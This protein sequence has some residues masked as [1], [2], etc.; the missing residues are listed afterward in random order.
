MKDML[1]SYSRKAQKIIR[2]EGITSFLLVASL[3]AVQ[4][5]SSPLISR[6]MGS[7]TRERGLEEVV[8]YAFKGGFSII[9][10][11]Q[12]RSEIIGLLKELDQRR[13]RCIIEIGTARGGT[14]FLLTRV[15]ADDCLMISIDLLSS[16]FRGGYP[17][18]KSPF[19]K[20]FAQEEQDLHL[21]RADSH[22][23][24][25]RKKVEDILE[26]RKAD[27]L[28]I[29]GDHSYSGVKRDFEVYCPLVARGGMVAFHDIADPKEGKYG[30]N[31]FWKEIKDSY[32]HKELI[33][34]RK[35]GWAGIGILYM[36]WGSGP[37]QL[38]Q[39]LLRCSPPP[40]CSPPGAG[41][42]GWH[43][44]HDSGASLID[45]LQIKVSAK[46]HDLLRKIAITAMTGKGSGSEDVSSSQ[47]NLLPMPWRSSPRPWQRMRV[48]TGSMAWRPRSP[49]LMQ[50]SSWSW[51]CT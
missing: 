3:N 40:A 35:Q 27:L 7:Y 47:L 9:R 51:L 22:D 17:E 21:L 41:L 31:E 42:A 25:T 38:W 45:I 28:F 20:S 24:A 44:S 6:R 43:L 29:D 37:R 8:D 33:E 23:S 19:Y 36:K 4:L 34:D 50:L 26:G 11:F 48:W 32:A 39:S 15:A 30:V 13:P 49:M 2:E 18:W 16:D 14:L 46:D 10:P 1:T 5:I 12:V